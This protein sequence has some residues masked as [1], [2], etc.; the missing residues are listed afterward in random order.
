[1]T[2]ARL[3][4]PRFPPSYFANLG[5][6]MCSRWGKSE[7][8]NIALAYVR[9]LAK[10]GDRWKKLSRK[11]VLELLSDDELLFVGGILEDDFYEP[12]FNTIADRVRSASGAFSV[13]GSWRQE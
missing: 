4:P 6:P 8:E 12:W 13:G 10:A 3:K 5:K 11:R 9:A 7:L 2:N 1:M